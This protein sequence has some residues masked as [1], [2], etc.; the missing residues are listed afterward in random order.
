MDNQLWLVGIGG[1][2]GAITR[3]CVNL[4]FAKSRLFPLGTFLVNITGSFFMGVLAGNKW[5]P[6]SASLLLGTGFLGAYTTFS[7]FNFE[8][9]MLKTNNRHFMFALYL[10]SSYI[11]GFLFAAFGYLL[12]KL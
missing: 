2:I 1:F 10:T 5:I 6:L 11:L 4:Y 7:T 8:L 12:A 9:I 3:Y